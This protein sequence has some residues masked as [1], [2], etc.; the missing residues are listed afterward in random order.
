MWLESEFIRGLEV[1][2]KHFSLVLP[3]EQIPSCRWLWLGLL[4]LT[5]VAAKLINGTQCL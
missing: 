4:P 1:R 2:N 3:W 5:T